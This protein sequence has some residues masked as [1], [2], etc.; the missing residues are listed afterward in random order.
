[1]DDI[2][3]L[4]TDKELPSRADA[5]QNRA[6]VLA[7][8]KNLFEVYGVRETSMS[9]IARQA[10]VGKGTLYRNFRSKSDICAALMNTAQQDFQNSTFDY[11]RHSNDNPL[12][13]LCWFLDELFFFTE[14]HIELLFEM[15]QENASLGPADL[16]HPAHH[17][18]WLTIVGLLR[19]A[20]AKGDLEYIADVIYALVE[21]RFYYFQRYIRRYEP[22]RIRNGIHKI[23]HQLLVDF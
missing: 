17:W 3:S 1:M 6:E 19:Q 13:L 21:P 9:Q 15:S 8:A 10:G 22:E 7:A 11:L 20:N 23:A 5:L 12:T 4:N 14:S 16:G 18:Q 2:L